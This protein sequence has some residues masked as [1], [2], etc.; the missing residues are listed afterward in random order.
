MKK[1]TIMLA[2]VLSLCLISCL[3]EVHFP[4]YRLTVHAGTGG[5]KYPA[6]ANVTIQALPPENL[7]FLAWEGDISGL[8]SPL[9]AI[10]RYRMPEGDATLS[11]YCLPYDEPSFRYEVF[12]IIQR[13]C[14]ID[15][16]HKNSIKQANFDDY[17]SVANK[18]SKMENFL[19][20]GFMPLSGVLPEQD[21]QLLLRWL[22][23]GSKNN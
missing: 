17:M 21:K 8:D 11:A 5:G 1:N 7:R 14:A 9:I 22:K 16:C 19:E 13:Y 18:A 20:I 6:R 3:K 2:G 12:P 23:L 10:A 4:L 15:D